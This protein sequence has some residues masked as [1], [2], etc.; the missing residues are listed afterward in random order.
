MAIYSED[1]IQEIINAND[2][3]EVVSGYVQL[4][5]AGRNYTGLCP[6][7]KE[8]TPSF[9]VSPDKQ[10]Y[11]CF[12]CGEGGNV[13]TFTMKTE[14]LEFVE[15]L[16]MLAQRVGITL[17]SSGSIYDQKNKEEKSRIFALNV[18]VANHFYKNLYSQ[19]GKIALEYLYNRKLDDDTIKK[20]GLGFS[21]NRNEMYEYLKSKG[22]TE[23]E[24]LKSAIV[25]KKENRYVDKFRNR[26][27]FPIVD[28]R[29]RV[30]AF[31]GRVLD[32]TK[33]KYINSPDTVIYNKGK[34]LF[35]LNVVKRQRVDRI[36][37]VEGYMDTISLHQRG[38]GN[39]V[40][41]LGTALT[42]EQAKL[43]SRYTK[44]IIVGYDSDEAGQAATLRG[45]DILTSVGCNVKVLQLDASDVKDPDEYIIKYGSGRFNKL[46]DN[47]I[48]L[49]EYKLKLLLKKYDISKIDEKIKFLNEMAKIL[50]SIDND[51]E[52]DAYVKKVSEYT[53]IT[54]QP[55]YAEINKLKFKY[56]NDLKNISTTQK[57][58]SL[59]SKKKEQ[60]VNVMQK[61]ELYI[62]FLLLEKDVEIYN[63]IKKYINLE[64]I[65][66][67]KY[68]ELIEILYS[69]YENELYKKMD[70]YQLFSEEEDLKILS[71]TISLEYSKDNIDKIIEDISK[72]LNKNRLEKRK[73]EITQLIASGNGDNIYDLEKELSQILIDIKKI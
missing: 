18:E 29:D 13:I 47:A 41:S 39:V 48:T 57:W 33:P 66:D 54:E 4:K 16:E 38:V 52:V 46:L 56:S 68:R 1:L 24:I 72:T 20:F 15:A 43:L 73:N 28:T 65:E 45:L 63:T 60:N 2:I 62:I 69:Y 37:I 9:M 71:S 61:A 22:F 50:A 11:H 58:V 10:I 51:I 67:K 34:N 70:V 21:V 35:A 14:G 17:K 32:N 36:L 55:I 12:G 5:R 49:V 44:E 53:A 59:K 7:H 27:M 23:N 6:F 30:I 8:K 31:G 26:L 25:E 3:V 64:Y 42:I 19:E 40:A